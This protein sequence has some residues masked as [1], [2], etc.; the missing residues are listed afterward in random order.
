MDPNP[1]ASSAPLT[2]AR[3]FARFCTGLRERP[4]HPAAVERAKH[5]FIDYIAIALHA[6]TLDSSRPACAGGST[7]DPLPR[8]WR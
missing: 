3:A 5:F 2:A 7:A 1:N 8:R 4:L 6:S